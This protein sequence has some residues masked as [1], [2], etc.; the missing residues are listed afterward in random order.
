MFSPP[1]QGS[2]S[3]S[4]ASSVSISSASASPPQSEDDFELSEA[5]AAASSSEDSKAGEP[6]YD[7]PSPSE[8]S[9]SD[10]KH[11]RVSAARRR[12]KRRRAGPAVVAIASISVESETCHFSAAETAMLQKK[13][14]SWYVANCRELP[15]RAPPRYRVD[16]P[17]VHPTGSPLKQSSPGA[18]YAVWVSEVMS[19]QTRLSVVV[20][21]WKRWMAAF[22]TVEALAAAPLERV[23]ELWSGLG[24]YRRAKFLHEAAVQLM[25]DFGGDLPRNVADLL[26]V[27]GIGAY[28]AGAISS[29][30]FN[31]PVPAVDGNVERV[32][33]RT[34]P[35]IMPNRSPSSTLG[36]KAKVYE[37]LARGLVTDIECA[38]DFNQGLMELGATICTPKNPLCGSCPIQDL[39]GS[40]ADAKT[41]GES[42]SL[43]A[44][45]YPVKDLSRKTKS[46]DEVVLVCAV[47]RLRTQESGDS[48]LEYLLL[49]RP[50]S[51]LLAGLW[52]SP[53]IVL[54][55]K[56]AAKHISTTA[57]T[58][59]MDKY[60]EELLPQIA[61]AGTSVSSRGR[62]AVGEATHVFSHIRQ[63]LHV[64]CLLVVDDAPWKDSGKA[65][66]TAFRWLPETKITDSAVATQ[67]RKALKL[68]FQ[69]D[70]P[71]FAAKASAKRPRARK[72]R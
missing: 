1:A 16:G 19:Q 5:E 62:K 51:G 72:V 61:G 7:V 39:C 21:Y 35:G 30:A 47:S 46:R 10:R 64:E 59:L 67:M 34:R 9:D 26:K 54:S 50:A 4:P 43:Y 28:T 71:R 42:P 25:S 37:K 66:G 65:A 52:E 58:R 48:Q 23:N 3:G 36:A 20:D 32:M 2:G 68:A 41:A 18:P 60:L 63:E 44:E 6:E 11:A 49:Q 8:E 27:K 45:R 24:Y 31:V 53:N 13:L 22:P 12:T 17:A 29:I 38:G 55:S 14:L 57:R 56:D 15:W 69:S 40:Y 33:A 70:K